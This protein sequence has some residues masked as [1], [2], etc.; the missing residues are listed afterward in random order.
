MPPIR[1][2]F[3]PFPPYLF[4]SLTIRL[5]TE[6]DHSGYVTVLISEDDWLCWQS[7]FLFLLQ[8]CYGILKVP[9]GNWLCRICAL[10]VQPKCLLCP[11]RGGA[12]KP[13]RS[14]TKW[15]HVSC[16][17]WIPEVLDEVSLERAVIVFNFRSAPKYQ[18]SKKCLFL[19]KEAMAKKILN[20][21]MNR[22]YNF[23]AHLKKKR[24]KFDMKRQ[25]AH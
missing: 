1:T 4:A 6:T 21:S 25:R 2:M 10:G 7:M 20:S 3:S 5:S 11:R 9:Q 13:T 12:L 15:V 16:A 8:A 22:N 24:K 19:T 14:G 23:L 18:L 17:L